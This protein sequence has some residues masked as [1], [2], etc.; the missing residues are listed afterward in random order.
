[1]LCPNDKKNDKPQKG[2]QMNKKLK[3]SLVCLLFIALTSGALAE[4]NLT[5]LVNEI[6]PA[7]VTIQTYDQN[8]KPLGQGTGFFININTLITN[9][10]VLRGAHQA[11]LLYTSPSPRD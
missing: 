8:K 4:A 11:C 10:H 9:Y 3:F 1:M 2:R 5:E 7:I 6:R